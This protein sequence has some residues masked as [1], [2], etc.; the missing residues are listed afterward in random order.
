MKRGVDVTD[1]Q[2]LNRVFREDTGVRNWLNLSLVR[3]RIDRADSSSDKALICRIICQYSIPWPL[4]YIFTP[5][6]MQTYQDMFSNLMR[7]EFARFNLMRIGLGRPS[8]LR[9]RTAGL[10]NIDDKLSSLTND[11][12]DSSSVAATRMAQYTISVLHDDTREARRLY[13]F[14]R[15]CISLLDA[16]SVHVRRD[17]IG[18]LAHDLQNAMRG[19]VGFDELI[20]T[21]DV[22]LS[23]IAQLALVIPAHAGD[24][25]RHQHKAIIGAH[26]T[27]VELVYLILSASDALDASTMQDSNVANPA[28]SKRYRAKKENKR[29]NYHAD[30]VDWGRR[31]KA[32]KIANEA[33]QACSDGESGEENTLPGAD[34]SG[35][36]SEARDS[37]A[38]FAASSSMSTLMASLSVD[39]E[40]ES[41]MTMENTRTMVAPHEDL[42]RWLALID[43]RLASCIKKL[44]Q[45]VAA[46][47]RLASR[48][49]DADM[50]DRYSTLVDALEQVALDCAPPSRR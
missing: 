44:R 36:T 47:V 5:Q 15:R 20:S 9:A 17:T 4:N 12:G 42:E 43:W 27:I 49:G 35:D 11:E 29:H 26:N 13:S 18:M 10:G 39:A 41:T 45:H 31:A 14:R 19:T 34:R 24:L 22:G 40:Q 1:Y 32:R 16:L 6:V 25:D 28:K 23:R 50:R 38:P 46:L 21:H 30:R 7:L 33:D 3:L 48:S 2:F 37:N 8:V